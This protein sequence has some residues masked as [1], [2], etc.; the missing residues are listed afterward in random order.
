[1]YTL[2]SCVCVGVCMCTRLSTLACCLVSGLLVVFVMS[3]G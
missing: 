1:M 2:A 3:V